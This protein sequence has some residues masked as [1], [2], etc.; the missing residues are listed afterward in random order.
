MWTNS[1]SKELDQLAQG[2]A[3]LS[4]GTNTLFFQKYNDILSERHKDV[5][6]ARV[7]VHYCPQKENPNLTCLT[8][9]GDCIKY[10]GGVRTL[11]EALTTEKM[12]INSTISTTRAR[13]MCGNLGI[14]YLV[15]LSKSSLNE[16]LM[17]TTYL[18]SFTM[19]ACIVKF[20]ET[21][22][23]SHRWSI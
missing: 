19:A 2:R 14:F 5:T 22:T 16:S 9:G 21:C 17:R 10:L 3:Q 8:V 15:T 4:S 13:Y 1:F 23:D 7:V 12:V 6:Y 11:T 20:N 18:D